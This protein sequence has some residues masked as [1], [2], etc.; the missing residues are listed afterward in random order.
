MAS[1]PC[2]E[3]LYGVIDEYVEIL[4]RDNVWKHS[5]EA[6]TKL[7]AMSLGT[8]K[9]C[10]SGFMRCHFATYGRSTTDPSNIH[11]LIQIRTGPWNEALVGTMQIDTVAHCG[12]SLAGTFVYTVNATDVSTLWG[13]RR[14][15]WNKGQHMTVQSM[16]E[17]ER[18]TPF[19][20]IE[21]HPDSGSEFINWHCKR[22]CED[23]GQQMINPDAERRGISCHPELACP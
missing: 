7:L 12:N 3:N 6:T 18:G 5:E 14:A 20:I 13:A 8:M 22:W 9:K 1:E 19:S 21:W 17:I 10:V 15:Q 2:A 11:S 4:I 16:E 23:K